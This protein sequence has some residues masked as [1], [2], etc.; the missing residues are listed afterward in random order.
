[1][2][3]TMSDLNGAILRLNQIT[4]SPT[5]SYVK[6]SE[7][8][9]QP[10]AKCYHLDQSYG[11]YRLIRMCDVGSGTHNVSGRG[12]KA[13]IYNFVRAYGDGY[14]RSLADVNKI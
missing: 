11:G 14:L 5:Q 2:R 10:Q 8:K 1:M 4:C 3:I 12:T 9:Y 7:G 6:D 13:E